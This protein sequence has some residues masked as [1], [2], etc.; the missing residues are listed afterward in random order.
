MEAAPA[1]TPIEEAAHD[2]LR[3]LA[4][5]RDLSPHTVSAYR[6]DLDQFAE[7]AA[8]ARVDDLAS[9]DR[10]LIRRFVA[11]LSEN[12]YARRSIARK[13]SA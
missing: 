8:R 10:R 2:F 4:A 7:W 6:S 11:Y 12:H 5:E 13:A 9:I 3:A 1:G